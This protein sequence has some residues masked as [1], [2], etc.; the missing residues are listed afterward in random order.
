MLKSS[1][2]FMHRNSWGVIWSHPN[3]W[4]RCLIRTHWLYIRDLCMRYLGRKHREKKRSKERLTINPERISVVALPFPSSPRRACCFS[5]WCFSD[6]NEVV[7]FFPK[8]W[9]H[10]NY[11][12]YLARI[13]ITTWKF[14][15]PMVLLF[16][17]TRTGKP[18][19]M[20]TM[21]LAHGLPD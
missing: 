19:Q 8:S 5:C 18:N 13:W 2:A 21:G 1:R 12:S 3:S 15:V 10:D 6:R 17:G 11:S 9:Y 16:P 14:Q 4:E 7:L 20:N